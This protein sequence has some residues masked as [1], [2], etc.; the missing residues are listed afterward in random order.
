MPHPLNEIRVIAIR[1]QLNMTGYLLQVVGATEVLAIVE[2]PGG[3]Q[4]LVVLEWS[5]AELGIRQGASILVDLGH[6]DGLVAGELIEVFVVRGAQQDQSGHVRREASLLGGGAII[7]SELL[8]GHQITEVCRIDVATLEQGI[9]QS[10]HRTPIVLG[11]S[12]LVGHQNGE[13]RAPV[14]PTLVPQLADA[15][16]RVAG[17]HLVERLQGIIGLDGATEELL[18]HIGQGITILVQ[19]QEEGVRPQAI[20]GGPLECLLHVPSQDIAAELISGSLL[21]EWRRTSSS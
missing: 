16:R 12:A 18:G 3:Q 17:L 5:D 14:A 20:I 19:G 13:M 4:E 11:L 1:L 21:R 15:G 6:D 9:A 7:P 10:H 2:Y 8:L